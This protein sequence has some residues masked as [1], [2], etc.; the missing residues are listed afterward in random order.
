MCHFL[1]IA[2]IPCS[3]QKKNQAPPIIAP[4]RFK[5]TIAKH[6]HWHGLNLLLITAISAVTC[7]I[8]W[9]PNL[10]GDDWYFIDA[11]VAGQ[12]QWLDFRLAR[13]LQG[14][15]YKLLDLL[16]GVNVPLYYASAWLAWLAVCLLFYLFIARL[17]SSYKP[18]PLI[19]GLLFSIYP[20][21]QLRMWITAIHLSFVLLCTFLFAWLLFEYSRRTTWPWLAGA[22]GVLVVSLLDYEGQLGLVIIWSLLL[23]CADKKSWRLRLGLASPLLVS[24]VYAGWRLLRSTLVALPSDTANQ[25]L[26]NARQL[27]SAPLIVV[28]RLWAGIKVILVGWFAPW[29]TFGLDPAIF[30]PALAVVLILSLVAVGIFLWNAKKEPLPPDLH[31]P[32]YRKRLFWLLLLASGVAVCGYLP[33]IINY[34]PGMDFYT[35]RVNLFAIPGASISCAVTVLL[36]GSLAKKIYRQWMAMAIFLVFFVTSGT[37]FQ[38]QVQIESRRVWC[39][40]A[41]IWTQLKQLAPGLKDNTFVG[42]VFTESRY[43]QNII[44]RDAIINPWEVDSGVRLVYG[45]PTLSGGVI[46]LNRPDIASYTGDGIKLSWPPRTEPYSKAVLFYYDE[47]KDQL[48]VMGDLDSYHNTLD[49]L[50]DTHILPLANHDS[51]YLSLITPCSH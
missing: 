10:T 51:P 23:A 9:A 21:Y 49:Y 8:Y 13:P 29:T 7:W 38:I 50:P 5:D 39:E 14:T 43:G 46:Y 32:S 24:A 16:W 35:S 3:P 28:E 11:T 19:A 37:I 33:F 42:I 26:L 48:Q 25:Y 18:L 4:M 31:S 45:N 6:L 20:I 2:G 36:L 12:Y 1:Y 22:L 44:T 40:Q 30:V 15:F 17:L 27:L 41:R 34:W 47:G